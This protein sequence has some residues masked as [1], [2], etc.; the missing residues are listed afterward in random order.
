MMREGPIRVLLVDDHAMVRAGLCG[1]LQ[2]AG[3]IEVVG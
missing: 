2:A 3:Q 1:S